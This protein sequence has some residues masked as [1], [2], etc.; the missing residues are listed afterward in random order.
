MNRRTP[1]SLVARWSFTAAFAFMFV[2]ATTWAQPP[3]APTADPA[4]KGEAE[5]ANDEAIAEAARR[6]DLGLKL[7]AE[8]E[9]R[10]AVI[11]FERT[12]QITNDYRVL[13]NIGQVRIQ[14]GNY[15]RAIGAL[16]EYLK[17]GADTVSEDRRKAV[18]ADLEMLAARTGHVRIVVNVKRAEILVDDLVVGQAPLLE[19]ILLD[20]GEHKITARAKGYEPRTVQLTLAGRDAEMVD[21]KL[22]KLPE[23]GSRIIVREVDRTDN[24]TWMIATWSAAGVF[25]VGAGVT[26]GLG[27]KAASDLEDQR[28]E[29]GVSNDEREN[30]SR[31]ARTLFLATDVLGGL[32]IVSA[33]VALY[34]TLTDSSGDTKKDAPP[35]TKPAPVRTSLALGPNRIAI[36]GEF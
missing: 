31:R 10:L 19:P 15:A 28:S 11:E 36:K 7:Y 16:K 20:A 12:Y 17:Q 2:P 6:Y 30:T 35:K 9:F 32:A 34:F 8:G 1:L 24:T 4:S 22:D 3:A 13:Y 21:L 23:G 25:A 29:E 26:G 18:E 33:G 5:P 14:L 27:L